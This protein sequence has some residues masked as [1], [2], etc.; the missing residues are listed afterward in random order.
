MRSD[1]SGGQRVQP[2]SWGHGEHARLPA[3]KV[4]GG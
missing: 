4:N 3:G 1:A 2:Y